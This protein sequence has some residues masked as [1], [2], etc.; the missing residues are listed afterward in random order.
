MKPLALNLSR[1]RKVADD[2]EKGT[3]TFQ[4]HDAPHTIT[5]A[6]KALPREQRNY[7]KALPVYSEDKADPEQSSAPQAMARGGHINA[8][9]GD[10][11]EERGDK[12]QFG[13]DDPHDHVES[14]PDYKKQVAQALQ[15][16][17]QNV[18]RGTKSKDKDQLIESLKSKNVPRGTSGEKRAYYDN[19]TPDKPVSES[20]AD[21]SDSDSNPTPQASNPININIGTPQAP[22]PTPSVAAS[23]ALAKALGDK[24]QNQLPAVPVAAQQG[25]PAVTDDTQADSNLSSAQSQLDQ[26]QGNVPQANDA[27]AQ[28]GAASNVQNIQPDTQAPNYMGALGQEVGGQLQQA[29]ALGALGTEQAGIQE[30]LAQDKQQVIDDFQHSYQTNQAQVSALAD[31]VRKGFVNPNH[32]WDNHSK[33]MTGLG[34]I[35]AGFNPSNKPNA[36]MEFLQNNIQRDTQAQMANLGAKQDLLNHA[37]QMFGNAH[38]AAEFTNAV[39]TDEAANHLQAAAAKSQNAQQAAQFNMQAGALKRSASQQ[40]LP[41]SARMGVMNALQKGADPSEALPQLRAFDKPFADTVEN[42][43]FPRATAGGGGT[44]DTPITPEARAKIAA[45]QNVLLKTQALQNFIDTNTIQGVL[46][47]AHRA[48]GEALAAELAQFYRQGTGASTSESEQKTISNFID[49][50]PGGFLSAYMNDP[51]LHALTGSMQDS[52]NTQKNQFGF[53]PFGGAA[54]APQ[55]Q[56]APTPTPAAQAPSAQIQMRNGK[57]YKKVPG[58]WIPA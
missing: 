51:R 45:Q 18:P 32:Y 39:K 11:I 44:T 20:D 22:S 54:Q 29:K 52:I 2:P 25:A 56:A 47:P 37:Y 53:H 5:I 12:E 24:G 4:S 55:S 50:K 3:S 13:S 14:N 1:F 8:S 43:L 48:E 38:S 19:G 15:G 23:P 30:R 49:Q 21:S 58:G 57:P 27:Q 33:F 17:Y 46:S 7:L 42:H 10:A 28:G 40:L 26:L 16:K 35:L 34:L 41:L 36:A 9:Y 6:H 31:D